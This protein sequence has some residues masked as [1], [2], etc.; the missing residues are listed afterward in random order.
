MKTNWI[1]WK[2]Q[3][4]NQAQTQIASHVTSQAVSQV[5]RHAWGQVYGMLWDRDFKHIA[6]RWDQ[7]KNEE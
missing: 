6:M 7:P 5:I 3:A 2:T 1:I 4:S